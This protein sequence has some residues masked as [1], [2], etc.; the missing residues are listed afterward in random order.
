MNQNA[1]FGPFFVMMGLTFLV[2]LFMYVKRIRFLGSLELEPNELTPAKLT[3]IS[4]PAV[5]NP[6]DNLKNLFEM[7][8][9]FYAMALYLFV[10]GQ[11]DSVHLIAAWVFVTFRAAH[12]AVHCTVNVVMLRFGLYALSSAALWFM[13]LRTVLEFYGG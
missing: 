5:A 10:V 6:S 4:P 12:S 11:V 2:W 1:I 7:P 8:V 9:L 13:V 3:E